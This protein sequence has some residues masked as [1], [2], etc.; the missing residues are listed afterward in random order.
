MDGVLALAV[1]A[2]LVVPR[3]DDDG[4]GDGRGD[5]GNVDNVDDKD[6]ETAEADREDTGESSLLGFF[7]RASAS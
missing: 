6:T 5:D 3:S 1:V 7:S 4:V 2:A